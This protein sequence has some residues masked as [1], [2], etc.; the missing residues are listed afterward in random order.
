MLND[1]KE[2]DSVRAAAASAL[3][4]NKTPQATV[5]LVQAMENH[6]NEGV[7]DHAMATLIRN[8]GLVRIKA[9]PRTVAKYRDQLGI[10]SARMRKRV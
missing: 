6:P 1:S 8:C 3:A 10:L 4:G 2:D 9:N 5:L 7:R